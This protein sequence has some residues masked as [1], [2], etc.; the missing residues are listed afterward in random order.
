MHGLS[1]RRVATAGALGAALMVPLGIGTA[2]AGTTTVCTGT[3]TGTYDAIVVPAGATCTLDGAVVRGNV[4]VGAGATLMTYDTV[5]RLNVFGDQAA[6]VNIIDTNVWGQ[7]HFT[8]TKGEII[9]GTAGCKVDP[10]ADGNINLQNN[11]G[12]IAICMMTVKNNILLHNNHNRIGVFDNTV[13][14]GIQVA[15][16]DSPAIRLRNNTVGHN[17]ALRNNDVKIAF[18]AKNNIIGGQGQ[19]FGNDIAPT[20][21]GNTAGGG[22]TGQCTNLD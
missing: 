2:S 22:L 20:G 17:M 7:I 19:C 8:R 16:N 11:Y 18:V 3:L 21:S 15:G 5:V 9:I 14:G 10:I 1:S 13:R 12:P 4:K 6:K